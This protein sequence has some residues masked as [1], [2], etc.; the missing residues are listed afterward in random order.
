M[1]N[2][3]NAKPQDY[4]QQHG[5]ARFIINYIQ[6][7]H[8]RDKAA[9]DIGCGYG[10]FA[11]SCLTFNP[12]EIV[13][14]DITTQDV[15]TASDSI[16]DS[17]TKFLVASALD[18]PF[19]DGTFDTVTAWEVLE[20]IPRSTES[21]F[22]QEVH[23]V[24]KPGGHF[25]MST[26]HQ[27]FWSCIT[28]PAWWLIGHRHYSKNQ[29]E[30]FA[31]G[32]AFETHDVSLRGNFYNIAFAL[33]MYVAKWIFRRDPFNQAFFDRKLD[34]AFEPTKVGFVGITAHFSKPKAA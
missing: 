14:I 27:S 29:I 6:E 15:A 17:R 20:H 23:R 28:D 19:A 31:N 18:L 13:G 33:N 12:R 5:F 2:I 9:L 22:F 25:Y 16:K 30:R 32:V 3:L 34:Q 10:S 4:S 24:L 11:L 1:R 21:K 7:S 26:P 8:F